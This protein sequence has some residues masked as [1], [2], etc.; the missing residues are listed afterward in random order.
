MAMTAMR[1]E[2]VQAAVPVEA[3]QVEVRSRVVMTV[4]IK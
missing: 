4:A 3:G 2:M 1:A